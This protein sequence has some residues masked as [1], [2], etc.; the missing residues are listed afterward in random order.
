VRSVGYRFG[1]VAWHP[2]VAQR[3][4]TGTMDAPAEAPASSTQATGA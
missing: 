4:G 3:N 2:G 1:Q